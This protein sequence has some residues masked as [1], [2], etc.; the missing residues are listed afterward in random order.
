MARRSSLRSTLKLVVCPAC[1]PASLCFAIGLLQL[2]TRRRSCVREPQRLE[3]G[4]SSRSHLWSLVSS[5]SQLNLLAPRQAVRLRRAFWNPGLALASGSPSPVPSPQ[6][7]SRVLGGGALSG[8]RHLLSGRRVASHW[9]AQTLPDQ[10]GP[11]HRGP[12]TAFV[13]PLSPRWSWQEHTCL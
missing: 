10:A 4:P 11:F 9:S 2:A 13:L 6:S 12:T 1:E 8:R 7:Q 3:R 5:R